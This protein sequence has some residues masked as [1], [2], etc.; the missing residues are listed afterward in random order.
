MWGAFQVVEK[1]VCTLIRNAHPDYKS[2]LTEWAALSWLDKQ[3]P[4]EINKDMIQMICLN[5]WSWVIEYQWE[6]KSKH[7]VIIK[8]WK[9]FNNSSF[10]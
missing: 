9:V 4:Q 6:L 3:G 2:S 5:M 10:W 1:I 7:M 8:M